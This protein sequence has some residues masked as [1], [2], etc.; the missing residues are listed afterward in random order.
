MPTI[1]LARHGETDWNAELRWQGH[2]DRPL[3]EVG[4]A[5]AL[6]LA[7]RLDAFALDAVFSSDLLRAR[8]T[9]DSVAARRDLAV[10]IRAD[11]REVDCGSWSGLRHSDLDPAAVARWKAGEKA[12]DGGESYE[13]MATR[14]VGAVQ[15][16]AAG[17][18]PD[19]Q[20]LVVS[21][22]AA[23]RAVLARARAMTFHEYR[24]RHPTIVNAGL[25]LV[26]VDDGSFRLLNAEE[27]R[28]LRPL[29][30]TIRWDRPSPPGSRS[31]GR[32]R[33]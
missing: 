26:A 12:W 7:E 30:R 22:G 15:E 33:A 11:L 23:I 25:D 20:V 4:R 17:W 31:V 10:E 28:A 3:N 18:P 27:A 29:G 5:Q 8:A 13:Q 16:V 6:A 24:S 14:M 19:A 1:L 32:P 21:H 9:A 2:A